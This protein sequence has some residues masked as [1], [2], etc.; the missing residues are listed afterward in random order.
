MRQYALEVTGLADPRGSGI[1]R[2]ARKFTEALAAI[3]AEPGQDFE[4][5]LLCRA[6]RW[7]RRAQLPRLPRTRLQVWQEKLWP[8]RKP[9]DVVHA[10]G[11][12][13][14]QWSGLARVTTVY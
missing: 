6:S 9:Y 8:L 13:L 7:K 2:H 10:L 3:A 1:S 5:V 4:L 14:P 12:R 11:Y